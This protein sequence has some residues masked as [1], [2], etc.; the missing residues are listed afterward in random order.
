MMPQLGSGFCRDG[1][2]VAAPRG[3][4]GRRHA[5]SRSCRAGA[6]SRTVGLALRASN[7]G[8]RSFVA[9][10]FDDGSGALTAEPAAS[11]GLMAR[12]E[13]HEPRAGQ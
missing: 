6:L 11:G 8:S 13:A 12:P 1:Q 9:R 2:V 5:R 10:C 4:T 3:R 7:A